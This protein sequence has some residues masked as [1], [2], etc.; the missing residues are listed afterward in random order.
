MS[1]FCHALFP[2]PF[3]LSDRL[4]VPELC[5]SCPEWNALAGS[6]CAKEKLDGLKIQVE[7]LEAGLQRENLNDADLQGLRSRAEPILNDLRAVLELLSPRF[8]SAKARLDQL[9]PA[10]KDAPENEELAKERQERQAQ[11]SEIDQ[12]QRLTR[13]LIGQSEQVMTS[14]TDRRRALFARALFARQMSLAI[15]PVA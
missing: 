5:G 15:L 9:G 13:S 1:L 4:P 14:A 11:F 2:D 12:L 6:A 3:P 8:D 7:Q 10:P